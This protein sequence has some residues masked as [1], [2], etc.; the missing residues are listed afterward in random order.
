MVLISVDFTIYLLSY[1]HKMVYAYLSHDVT[2]VQCNI[3]VDIMTLYHTHVIKSR[4]YVI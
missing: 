2:C 1:Y 3:R 4:R